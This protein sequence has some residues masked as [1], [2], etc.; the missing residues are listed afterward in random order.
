MPASLTHLLALKG[1]LAA[2]ELRA[3]LGVSPATLS[4]LVAKEGE[5]VYRL[6]RGRATWYALPRE[7]EGLPRRLPVYRVSAEGRATPVG[8]LLPLSGGATWVRPTGGAG[9]VHAGLPPVVV[10]MAPSGYPGRTFSQRFPELELPP[11][12]L[13]WSDN[14]R[15]IAIARRGEDLPGDLI[16]GD[17]SLDRF[18]AAK[19]IGAVERDYPVLADASA[20]GAVGSSAGGE[21]PKF[22]AAFRRRQ[23]L[24]KFT[25]GDGS[26]SDLRWRDLL[27]AEAIALAVLRK[28][29]VPAAQARVLDVGPRRFLE[30]LRFD[31]VGARGRR[32]V[33]SL[34]PMDDDL[35]GGRDTWTDAAA[36]LQAEGLLS[37][38]HARRVRLLEAFGMWIRN[39][40][41]H[42]GNLSFFADGLQPRPRLAL[43]PA[44]DML[45]MDAAPRAGVVPDLPSSPVVPRAKLLDVWEEA[46]RLARELW[47]RV[48]ADERISAAF[49]RQAARQ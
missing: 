43:A 33:L 11:R 5:G 48:A 16:V 47:R 6:G 19:T 15:L 22:T 21:Q 44:Y 41:R 8:E 9:H 3:R 24:V 40:D 32:G 1:P 17:E 49:R 7:I 25:P 26:P 29:G 14:H 39:G 10:D 36:R 23:V 18:L 45:P 37:A 28:A 20:Q 2:A 27:A 42:F 35:F 31:R 4:R 13:D 34:G 46:E 12:I 38:E 30:V